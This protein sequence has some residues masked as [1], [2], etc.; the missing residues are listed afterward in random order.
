MLESK[1]SYQIVSLNWLNTSLNPEVLLKLRKSSIQ[2]PFTSIRRQPRQE[3][4]LPLE[5]KKADSPDP[6]QTKKHPSKPQ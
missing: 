2:L 5:S 3:K 1:K 6:K 4:N